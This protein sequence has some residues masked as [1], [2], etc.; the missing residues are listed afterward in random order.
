MK[1]LDVKKLLVFIA[2]IA[3]VALI[4]IFGSKELFGEKKA[5]AEESEKAEK[6]VTTYFGNLSYGYATNYRGL[7]VLYQSDKTTL[8]D[9]ELKQII[10]SS[11]I[12]STNNNI[13]TNVPY[14]TLNNISKIEGFSNIDEYSAYSGEGLRESAKSLFGIDLSKESDNSDYGYL[15]DFIYVKEYDTYLMKRNKVEDIRN[16]KQGIDYTIVK[17]TKKDK[18]IMT[19]LAI[20]YTYEIDENT[21][22][23]AKDKQGENIIEESSK[24]FPKDKVDEFEKYTF[25]MTE[26]EDGN[27]IFK[28]VEK[29]K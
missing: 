29:V 11:I 13:N 16:N 24:E 1:N 2:I 14:S 25:T 3:V 6:L 5:S 10:N 18:D 7:D 17:T 20:A 23:F 21:R 8:E 27:Y 26:N 28:S 15:Y 12:F 9:L 4:V 22:S 19:T